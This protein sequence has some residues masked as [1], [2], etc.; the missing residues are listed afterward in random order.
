MTYTDF[1]SVLIM[2]NNRKPNLDEYYTN[3]YQNLIG[4]SYGYKLVCFNNQFSKYFKPYLGQYALYKFIFS[5][6]KESK[7]CCQ[8]KTF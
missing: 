2:E 4:C 1:E 6:V 3:K 5:I 7:C 8:Q